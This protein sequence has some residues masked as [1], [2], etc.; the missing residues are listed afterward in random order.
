MRTG[1]ILGLSI[2]AACPADEDDGGGGFEPL[3]CAA[4]TTQEAC[5]MTRPSDG[6]SEHGCAWVQLRAADASC[7]T[8]PAEPVG[9]CI[10]TE[11][12]GDGCAF[13]ECNPSTD[14]LFWRD[15]DDGGFEVFETDL[16]GDEPVGFSMCSFDGTDPAACGCLCDDLGGLVERGESSGGSTG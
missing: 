15:A 9:T 3:N 13:S 14:R 4:A 2:L 5:S 10:Q 8:A 7:S 12:Q 16:C 6:G 1:L 11:F